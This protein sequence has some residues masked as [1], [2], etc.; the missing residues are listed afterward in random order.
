MGW[1]ITKT[2]HHTFADGKTVSHTRKKEYNS[3][4]RDMST[5]KE[6]EFKHPDTGEVHAHRFVFRPFD[7][8]YSTS[9]TDD[10]DDGYADTSNV[11]LQSVISVKVFGQV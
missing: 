7:E 8:E 11:D 9:W 2:H 3:A 10:T 6:V 5:E 1:K 4:S